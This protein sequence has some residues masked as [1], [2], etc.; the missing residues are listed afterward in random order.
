MDYSL[1]LNKPFLVKTINWT[2]LSDA[3][4]LLDTIVFP[5]S[6]ANNNFL[7]TP[8]ERSSYFRCRARTIIQVSGTPMYSGLLLASCEPLTSQSRGGRFWTNC[9]LNAPHAFIA[10]CESGVASIEIPFY[11]N[12]KVARCDLDT[13]QIVNFSDQS[14]N[15]FAGLFLRVMNKLVAPTS[16]TVNL[17]VTVHVVF[18]ELEFYAPFIEPDWVTPPSLLSAQ[19]FSFSSIFSTMFDNL[20]SGAKRVTGDIIDSTRSLVRQYTGLDNGNKSTINN[21]NYVQKRADLNTVD[22]PTVYNKLDPYHSYDR[23]MREYLFETS[24]DEMLIS[25]IVSKPQFIGSFNVSNGDGVGTLKWV[26]P[27]TPQQEIYLDSNGSPLLTANLS[28]L[29]YL[30]RYWRGSLKLHIQSNMTNFHYAKLAVFKS[31]TPHKNQ[32]SQYPQ[33]SSIQGLMVDFLEFSGG[34]QTQTI[35]L[36]FC[37]TTDFQE[38]TRDWL[39]NAFQHGTYFVYVA[40]PLIAN[41]NVSTSISFNMYLSAGDDFQFAGYANDPAEL[42]D[43][44]EIALATLMDAQSDTSV[45]AETAVD[46][47]PD[48]NLGR[49]HEAAQFH[50][51]VSVRDLMR[52]P[53]LVKTYSFPQTSSGQTAYKVIKV[54]DLVGQG[55][56]SATE[57]TNATTI[58]RRFFYGMDGGARIKVH[59]KGAGN[60]SAWYVPPGT[61][62]RSNASADVTNPISTV[63]TDLNS[64]IVSTV[65]F[66]GNVNYVLSPSQEASNYL[67][68]NPYETGSTLDTSFNRPAAECI[69]DI[70]VPNMNLF[71]FMGDGIGYLVDNAYVAGPTMDMGT[72]II[73]FKPVPKIVEGANTFAA[74]LMRVYSAITDETR[75]GFQVKAPT[76]RM[77]TVNSGEPAVKYITTVFQ[78]DTILSGIK[79]NPNTTCGLNYFGGL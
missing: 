15:Q 61:F 75:C 70:T 52:R 23:I 2:T 6:F 58:V 1:F 51:L 54:A 76:I 9:S 46:G 67:D 79:A 3:Y 19:S 48:I 65:S 25:N 5:S 60:A 68:N 21:R 32:I 39:F 77:P 59:I 26:R 8:F 71:R 44:T 31:Y 78:P 62:I 33:Y 16:G 69:L 57:P 27:I 28:V 20:A 12:T 22:T 66:D 30:T 72:L 7:S 47:D 50:P 63:N 17:S 24:K 73:A 55:T 14:G 40:Q 18:D 29:S 64:R 42:V 34:G 35:D 49:N 41:G 74:V 38:C 53:T 45:N 11:C 36:P 4:S 13:N 37:S 56:V 43:N 10:A